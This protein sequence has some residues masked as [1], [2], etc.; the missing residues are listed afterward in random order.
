MRHLSLATLFAATALVS[1]APLSTVWADGLISG[2][3]KSAAGAPLGGVAVSA[4]AE[5]QSITT[6]VYTD[7]AGHY[8]FPT[9]AAG[10]YRVWAQAVTFN[11]ARSTVELAANRRQDFTLAP[12]ADFFKQLTGDQILAGLPD[13][14]PHDKWMKRFVRVNCS[15]CHTPSFTLQHR[16]DEAGWTAVLDLMKRAN[17]SGIYQGDEAKPNAIIDFHERE[18]AEYLARARGPGQTSMHVKPRPRPAGEAARV[19]VTEYDVPIDPELGLDKLAT[20]D[21]SDW[22]LG[23]PSRAGAIV[24]D[25]WLDF[26]GNLWFT[27]NTPNH[28][29][30][31]GRIDGKTGAAKMIKIDGVQGR[32][33]Q[34]HGM[35]R[36][37]AGNLWFNANNGHGGLARLDP[38]TEKIE[39]FMPPQGMSGTGG[40]TTV[41]IDGKGKVWVS[42]PDGILRFDPATKQFTEFKSL[43]FKTSRG[44]GVTYGVAA[45]RDGNGW[46]AQMGLDIVDKADFA[47]G[48]TYSIELPPV[49]SPELQ[50]VASNERAVYDSYSQADFNNPL[51]W[52]QGPRRMGADKHGDV[53]WVGNSHGG[54]LTRI[55]TKT[56]QTTIVPLPNQ[57]SQYPYHAQVDSRHNVWV[58]MMNADQVMRYDPSSQKATYF[59]LPNHGA[60]TRYVSLDERGGKMKVVMPYSRTSK[61]AVMTFR[62]PADMA[63]AKA[64]AGQ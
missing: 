3:I 64:Q 9:L 24:H 8:Y 63:A 7:S 11:T 41:D 6:S 27:C 45:D 35:T 17:V 15:S 37:D 43:T 62:S 30:T 4:K 10:K 58:N 55:D 19:V 18:L 59:D 49:P 33:A 36:D 16:F 48:K 42:A 34:A 54:S 53:I 12:L 47:A 26:A 22:M 31:I 5:G 25:S 39:L 20:N 61:I 28:N 44:L 23:T 29:T 21:G 2:T 32:A 13:A 57:D 38:K 40:A 1:A 46:W 50:R 51:P 52:M 14:D 56:L 60:E